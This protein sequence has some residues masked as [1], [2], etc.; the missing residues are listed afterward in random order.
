M[1]R[2]DGKHISAEPRATLSATSTPQASFPSVSGQA[3]T[4]RRV[5]NILIAEDEDSLASLYKV[6]LTKYG[7]RVLAVVRSGDEVVEIYKR[8]SPK[9][10]VVIMDHRLERVSGLEALKEILTMDPKARVIFASADDSIMEDAI[11]AG[12]VDYIGKPFSMQELVE[13]I[14]RCLS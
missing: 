5:A 4:S 8:A 3:V 2:A 12:A 6:L 10:D 14:V 13:V 7:H 1:T 11:S 9:P